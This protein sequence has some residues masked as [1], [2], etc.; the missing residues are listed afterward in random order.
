MAQ[1]FVTDAGTLI[2]PGA[3]PD[4][5][6]EAANSGLATTGVLMLVGEAD[7]GPDYSKEADLSLNSFGPDQLAEVNAK[8]KSGRL[9]DAFRSATAAAN[10]TNIQGS[11]ARAIL[12]KTNPSTKATG[13]LKKFSGATYATIQDRSYGK[14]GNLISFSVAAKSSEVVPTTGSF[15]FLPPIA[16]TNISVRVNGGAASTVAISAQETPAAFATAVDAISGVDVTGGAD[17]QILGTSGSPLACNLSLTVISGNSVRVDADTPFGAV[18]SAGDTLWIQ[19]GSVIQGAGNANRGA[20][21]VTSASS[22]TINAR[23]LIDA[24]GTPNQLTSP[25]NVSA[26]AS[27]VNTSVMAFSAISIHLVSS[28]D[29]IDGIGKSLEINE[30]TTGTGLLSYLCYTLGSSGPVAVTWISKTATPYTITSASEYIP[31]LTDARQFDSITEDLSEGGK[32]ALLVGYTGTTATLANDGKVLTFTLVGGAGSSLSPLTLNLAD[33]PSIAD[34]S[35]YLA[36]LPGFVAKPGTAT[37]G[38]QPSTSLDQSP[39]G[40]PFNIGTTF[41]G[42]TGRIKQ[43]AYKFYS[44]LKNDGVLVEL[45]AQPAAGV[46]APLA[47]SYLSGGTKGATTDA[48]YNGAIDAL[49]LVRGNFV[50]PLFSRDAVDDIADNLTDTNSTY[51]VANVHAYAKSH[52][53]RMST[54]KRRRNR[55][56]FLSI[57]D[58]FNKDRDIAANTASFRACM[59]FQDVKD[60]GANGVKQFQPWMAGV[61]AASMQAAGFY[62]P[63]V[64]K[65]INISGALQAKGDFNDQNDT[66]MEDALQSGL[67]PIRRDE[68]GGFYWVSDQTTYGKDSNFVYNSIQATYVADVIALS[69]AQRM[70]KAFVGQSVA[71]V[72]A[73]LAL[74]TLEAIMDDFRRLKLIAPSDDAPKGFKNA[75]VQIKGPAMVVFVEVKLA[76]AIYFIPI[77]FLVSQVQQS[78]G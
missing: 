64:R 9:V 25:V 8:Y 71:D 16:A 63:I 45:D 40:V 42:Y 7:A 19:A 62:R 57:R 38:S 17:L 35:S 43:D 18:P 11:F 61:K 55:Q 68:T 49:E 22:L 37:M 12:V 31:T 5:R 59:P 77:Q 30:L 53:L 2:I 66:Q 33:F 44:K 21:I 46:P 76:G 1:S 14:L 78:A 29:P 41:A 50:I 72:S 52:V 47:I 32:I 10:D 13:V 73:S 26:Q 51:T 48:V 60:V 20:Y 54:L 70:E 6:V 27:A 65:G 23:K 69:T 28:A 74:S 15:A 36:A 3:Y 67:L 34:L 58:T 39:V 75:K 4:I 24:T 56:V